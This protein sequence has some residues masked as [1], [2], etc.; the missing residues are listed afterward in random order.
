[1]SSIISKIP[2]MSIEDIN[3]LRINARKLLDQP[4][5]YAQASEVL[6]ALDKELERRYL[7]GMTQTFLEQNPD[8]FYGE[9]HKLE[10][11]D[12]KEEA[13]AVCQKQLN[14]DEFRALLD[15]SSYEELIA[16]AAKVINQTTFIQGS[17]EKP[18][19]LDAIRKSPE[20]FFPALYDVLWSDDD[21]PKRF[22][23]FIQRME[24][25]GLN[26][27]TYVTYFPFLMDPDNNM[28]V[29]PEMLKKSLDKSQY[30]LEYESTPSVELYL[31]I[32]EFSHWLKGKI[33]SLKPRDL[34]DIHSFMWH[35][36]PTGKWSEE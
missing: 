22:G 30:P 33:A 26:K 31:G 20:I 8:G 29:K 36:G 24:E 17:F 32:I 35:M 2:T 10:E 11:R 28:F 4:G 13:V 15:S 19:F 16:R 23:R 3:K 18:K 1:M 14:K 9:K 21:I 6:D 25:L 34:I 12:Y 5:R 7:P 27:W